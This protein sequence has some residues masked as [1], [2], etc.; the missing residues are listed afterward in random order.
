M[1]KFT[2]IALVCLGFVILVACGGG[3]GSNNSSDSALTTDQK[4]NLEAAYKLLDS[5]ERTAFTSILK[6]AEDADMQ[7]VIDSVIDASDGG[8]TREEMGNAFTYSRSSRVNPF[9]EG[10][11]KYTL[12]AA[13]VEKFTALKEANSELYEAFSSLVSGM[14]TDAELAAIIT[15]FKD[16]KEEGYS[17]YQE[18]ANDEL[19]GLIEEFVGEPVSGVVVDPYV[20][21]AR[22]CVDEN[23][24]EMCDANE[25]VS[26]ASD[27]SGQFTFEETPAENAYI[28]IKADETG[29]H[30]G[31]PYRMD[32]LAG[33]YEGG[34][35]V[36]SPLTTMYAEGLT[37]AQLV[38]MFTKAGL[39]GVTEAGVLSDPMT[40]I[41]GDQV[42]EANLDILRSFLATYMTLQIIAG[43][44][45]LEELEVSQIY[46]NVMA[47]GE[48]YNI[49]HTMAGY[50]NSA[51]ST[52]NLTSLQADMGTYLSAGGLP[53]ISFAD[54]ISVSVAIADKL[55]V[56]GFQTCN[57]TPGD[58]AAK[59]TAALTRV[60]TFVNTKTIDT[61]ISDLAPF[62]YL[63]RVQSQ[64]TSA[65][66]AGLATAGLSGDYQDVVN[67]A[68]KSFILDEN[69]DVACYTDQYDNLD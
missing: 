10:T 26:T 6:G 49:L 33:R 40:D 15:V 67:C 1:R 54:V 66:I 23:L 39:D 19:D 55:A 58:A 64:L 13:L 36:V 11:D 14:D 60:T 57:N 59:V 52:A 68:S 53:E 43:S 51:L 63:A 65:Q 35:I 34:N 20:V 5:D 50:L 4:T 21:G 7:S 32:E 16:M 3:S 31:I 18:L 47:N 27:A 46:T 62:F 61:M 69:G 45:T 22:F 28:L 41:L 56:L 29:L 8:L 38:E 48:I 42:T 25:P 17:E 2:L 37:A 30:N 12:F 24:N 44:D 9:E